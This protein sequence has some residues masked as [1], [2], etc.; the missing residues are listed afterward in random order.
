LKNGA[1][2][3]LGKTS[4][5]GKQVG[6]YKWKKSQARSRANL[7]K[8]KKKKKGPRKFRPTSNGDSEKGE[9]KF[10]KKTI[11]KANRE[12]FPR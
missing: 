3:R 1:N 4:K 8:R 9:R 11:E 5:G 7:K 6:K 10:K 12:Y 2:H